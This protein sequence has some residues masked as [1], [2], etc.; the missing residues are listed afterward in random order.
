MQGPQALQL[1][2]RTVYVQRGNPELTIFLYQ[3]HKTVMVT[4]PIR[5]DEWCYWSARKCTNF[6][7]YYATAVLAL[8]P[9]PSFCS[10]QLPREV[11]ISVLQTI[12]VTYS[13]MGSVH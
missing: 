3:S 11:L 12:S 2:A 9:W 13:A 8:W 4:V 10:Q 6:Q 7:I 5:S 1:A